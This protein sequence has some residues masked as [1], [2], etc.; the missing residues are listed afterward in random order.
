MIVQARLKLYFRI[1]TN[2]NVSRTDVIEM[3]VKRK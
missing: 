3:K 2:N 1:T